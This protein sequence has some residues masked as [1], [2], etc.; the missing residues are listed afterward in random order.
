LKNNFTNS[1]KKTIHSVKQFFENLGDKKTFGEAV[2]KF[3]SVNTNTKIPWFLPKKHRRKTF[4]INN[5]G[6]AH[7]KFLRSFRENF[8][9]KHRVHK[10]KIMFDFAQP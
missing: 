7:L 1:S 5:S 2:K 4:V 6:L 8:S 10:G 9:V 3:G